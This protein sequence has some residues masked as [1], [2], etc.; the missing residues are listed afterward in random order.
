MVNQFLTNWKL[1]MKGNFFLKNIN[2]Q[3][4][5]GFLRSQA[6]SFTD[7][8]NSLAIFARNRI[9]KSSFVDAFDFIL[10][11]RGELSHFLD[12]TDGLDEKDDPETLLNCSQ[13]GKIKSSFVEMDFMFGKEEHKVIRKVGKQ[14]V[15]L[16]NAIKVLRSHLKINPII[17]GYE[18][19]AFA[20]NRNSKLRFNFIAKWFQIEEEMI[21]SERVRNLRAQLNLD[22]QIGSNSKLLESLADH[23]KSLT[24]LE[25]RN[26]TDRNVLSFINEDLLGNAQGLRL[27][28]ISDK[29]GTQLQIKRLKS[30]AKNSNQIEHLN[31]ILNKITK[32]LQLKYQ[33][34]LLELL[35]Y[36]RKLLHQTLIK[37]EK[38]VSRELSEKLQWLLD[39]IES[40]MNE[41]YNKVQKKQR[42]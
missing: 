19:R 7:K 18:L 12:R 35:V 36:D 38:F 26:L 30:K 14:A 1:V 22:Q 15:K 34:N 41:I 21:M 20:E 39:R 29:N 40:Q 9:G 24:G 27:S 37:Q 13:E 5:R 32:I 2:I 3:G 6:I 8:V 23:L 31:Q 42:Q 16:P 10:S 11:E 4:F 33:Y 28:K 17:R 25:R